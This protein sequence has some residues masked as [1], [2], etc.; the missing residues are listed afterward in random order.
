MRSLG[1]RAML[2]TGLC[3]MQAIPGLVRAQTT[4][5]T[6]IFEEYGK[7]IQ[8]R[9]TV[10]AFG[11]D[12]FGERVGLYTGSLEFV[13]TDVSLPGN[14][15]LPVSLGRRFVPNQGLYDLDGHFADWDLEIPACMACSP[16][17]AYGRRR[18]RGSPHT[19]V[20][21]N[22]ARRPSSLRSNPVPAARSRQANTGRAIS[23]TSRARA[24]RKS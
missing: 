16:I 23:C 12:L 8:R 19:T 2:L 7:L 1:M 9:G 18:V 24:M 10:A 13:Q 11:D 22:S 21:A 5:S 14:N 6:T 17:F 20:A 15:S 4:A 3:V